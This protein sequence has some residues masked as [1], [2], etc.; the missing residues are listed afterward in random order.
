MKRDK[1]LSL[2]LLEV[3]F[4]PIRIPAKIDAY[5]KTCQKSKVAHAKVRLYSDLEAKTKHENTGK[6]FLA[7]NNTGG[8]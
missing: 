3:F 1:L 5:R 4:Q 8:K 2:I 7:E 6:D